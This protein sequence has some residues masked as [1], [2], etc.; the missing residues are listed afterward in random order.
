MLEI[1]RTM[2]N[3]LCEAKDGIPAIITMKNT[4]TGEIKKGQITLNGDKTN[5][6]KAISQ[7]IYDKFKRNVNKQTKA[8]A[9]DKQ[10]QNGDNKNDKKPEAANKEQIAKVLTKLSPEEQNAFKL[11]YGDK[12]NG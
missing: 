10:Q 1:E 5:M 6:S 8:N 2:L 12:I 9:D 3:I 4:E 11:Y 7:Q